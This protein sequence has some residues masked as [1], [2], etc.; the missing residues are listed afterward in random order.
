[1]IFDIAFTKLSKLKNKKLFDFLTD[2][3]SNF[4]Y[5]IT[6]KDKID[7]VMS[8]FGIYGFNIPNVSKLTDIQYQKVSGQL[9]NTLNVIMIDLQSQTNTMKKMVIDIA[10]VLSDN[11][12]KSIQL[13]VFYTILYLIVLAKLQVSHD[14]N[15]LQ[16]I[17]YSGKLKKFI[18]KDDE[19]MVSESIFM[20]KNEED[21]IYT[22]VLAE[23]CELIDGDIAPNEA[24]I[25]R[26]AEMANVERAEVL[27]ILNENVMDYKLLYE[28]YGA[29]HSLQT[30]TNN[31][32]DVIQ[33]MPTS[34]LLNMLIKK[35][36]FL[37]ECEKQLQDKNSDESFELIKEEVKER[38][39]FLD[40]S[41][42]NLIVENLSNYDSNK[43]EPVMIK[44]I[45][46]LL[47]N[48]D[49]INHRQAWVNTFKSLPIAELCEVKNNVLILGACLK[50]ASSINNTPGTSVLNAIEMHKIIDDILD[51]NMRENYKIKSK[52]LL[53]G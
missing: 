25:T 15:L 3:L 50:I 29:V 10:K 14:S 16:V 4:L 37:N 17:R 24:L 12:D 44:K 28:I 45:T 19:A 7:V 38:Y 49:T 31:F 9:A 52:Q 40:E 43:R 34:M 11:N 48:Q 42:S 39:S 35:E 20:E 1:M 46:D 32:K 27:D 21:E 47:L 51:K 13:N 8:I 18:K 5:Q 33:R 53:N 22:S 6:E 2:N 23:I 30:T 36:K 26:L 41:T